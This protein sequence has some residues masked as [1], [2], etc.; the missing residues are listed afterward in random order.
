MDG[1]PMTSSLPIKVGVVGGGVIGVSTAW[2]LAR[3]GA[4]V[5][6]LT[7]SALTSEASGRSLSWLNSAG[8]GW[9][10]ST[11]IALCRLNSRASAG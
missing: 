8:S 7:A 4:D 6:L 2:Q 11:G 1:W 10:A 9:R 3:A 5:I